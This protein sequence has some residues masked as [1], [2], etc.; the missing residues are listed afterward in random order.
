VQP[1][2]GVNPDAGAEAATKIAGHIVSCFQALGRYVQ[3]LTDEGAV[4][5]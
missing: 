3:R 2:S 1:D 5:T 4:K